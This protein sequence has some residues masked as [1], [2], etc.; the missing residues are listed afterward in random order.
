MDIEQVASLL[1]K[2]RS[3]L[4]L[5]TEWQFIVNV[6]DTA[7]D[8]P[9]SERDCEAWVTV[10]AEYFKATFGFNRWLLHTDHAWN[11][12]ACH[13]VCHVMQDPI[14]GVIY[15]ALKR[16]KGLARL[17]CENSVERM[18]RALVELE[19]GHHDQ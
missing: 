11:L 14:E 13:E 9:K 16:H 10:Q 1:D 3:V 17:L 6:Y 8:A 5:G 4:G 19:G 12:A 7:A 2:W 18:S 15:K